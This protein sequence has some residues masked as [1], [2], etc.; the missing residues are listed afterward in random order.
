MI[1]LKHKDQVFSY[2]PAE[3][4]DLAAY[5]DSAEWQVLITAKTDEQWEKTWDFVDWLIDSQKKWEDEYRLCPICG[6]D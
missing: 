5:E 2:D 6:D 3:H 4:G 1:L